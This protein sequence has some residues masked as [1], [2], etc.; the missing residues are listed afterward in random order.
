MITISLCMIVKNEEDAIERCLLSVKDIVDEI[1]I[2]DTGSTDRTKE[3]VSRYTDM[4]YDFEWIDDFAAARNYAFAQATQAYILWLD[5]DD[6]FAEADQRKLLDLKA[7]LDPSVDSV[8]MN[9]HLSF[10]QN[11]NPATSLRRNRLVRRACQFQWIGAVHE[12][13][14][15]GGNIIDSDIA[16]THRKEKRHTDRNLK[17]YQKRAEKGEEF[18]PRDLYYFGNELRDH[19]LYRQA[20]EYYE[21]FLGTKLGWV[22]DN[23]AACLKLADIYGRLGERDNQL[24]SLLRTLEYDAA[25]A[26]FC[27]AIGMFFMQEN[28]WEQAKFWFHVA[29]ALN[30]PATWGTLDLAAWTWLP[31]LQLCVCYDRLGDYERARMH[32]EIALSHNPTHPSMLYNKA[33]FEEKAKQEQSG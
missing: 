15:V 20:I 25:R 11:G 29:T 4:I 7:S 17:I 3:I 10:D 13:L 14:A 22:E 9:Y 26:E 19:Q 23:I 8:T 21:K 5:A 32:N 16:V 31:H 30:K 12:Y 28:K 33:Y 1:I 2:V 24:R 27:C 6:V 18:S